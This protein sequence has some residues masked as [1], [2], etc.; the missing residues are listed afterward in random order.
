MAILQRYQ[1][2]LPALLNITDLVS[3]IPSRF[4]ILKHMASYLD[5][6]KYYLRQQ[7]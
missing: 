3:V 2:E 7:S 1:E 6:E 4:N 5:R